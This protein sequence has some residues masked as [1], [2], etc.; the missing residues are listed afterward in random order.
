M[1]QLRNGSRE[2]SGLPTFF[3]ACKH[4]SCLPW[5]LAP[6]AAG[7]RFKVKGLNVSWLMLTELGRAI[8]L[9]NM[10]QSKP[11]SAG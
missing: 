7:V 11:T 8:F 5:P 1:K 9:E 6:V 3:K 4:F 10:F 2:S